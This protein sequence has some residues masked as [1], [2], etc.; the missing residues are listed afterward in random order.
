[1]TRGELVRHLRRFGLPGAFGLLCLLAAALLLLGPARSW[2]VQAA[3]SLSDADALRARLKRQPVVVDAPQET[4]PRHLVA[5]LP[6][7]TDRQARL[8]DLLTLALKQG[9]NSSRTEHRITRDDKLGLER[10]RITMPVQGSYAQLRGFI[11]Q[12]LRQDP[13]LSLDSLKLRRN[14]PAA[15]EI[16]A[17]LVWS[18]HARSAIIE[19][20]QP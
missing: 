9:L 14:N 5:S 3:T 7:V 16:E 12:A 19:G 18:L 2:D 6:E 15:A 13:A 10:L 11:E 4:Q 1:M 17:E 8:G 20:R